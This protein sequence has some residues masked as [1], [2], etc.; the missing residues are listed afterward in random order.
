MTDLGDAWNN[1]M[2]KALDLIHQY[3]LKSFIQFVLKSPNLK[4]KL[5]EKIAQVGFKNNFLCKN[6]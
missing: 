5:L 4:T 1:P 2:Q 6:G 3:L